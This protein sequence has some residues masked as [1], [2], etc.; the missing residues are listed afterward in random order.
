MDES[1]R[2][3]ARNGNVSDLYTLIQSDGNVLKRL[4]EIEFIDTPLHMAAEQG[5]MQFAMEMMNLKPSFSRKLNHQGLSP[6]HLALDK[7]HTEMVLHFVEIDKKLIRVKGKNSETPLHYITRVGNHNGLLDRFLQACPDS[8]RDFTTQNSTA[9]H[10]A[11]ENNRID[12][13]QVL[14]RTLVKKGPKDY[15]GEV[16][17]RKDENGNTALHMAAINNQPQADKCATNQSG[18]TALDVAQQHN[19]EDSIS[20]LRGCFI[21]VVSNFKPKLE[22]KFGNSVTKA[23]SL[24]FRDMDNIS[25][26]DRNALLVILGLLLT[27][28][29]Q[30]TLSP[31]GGISQSLN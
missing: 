30:A 10:I 8:I 22:K 15:Y 5:C 17:N 19:Y 31:P 27:A 28:T 25:G 6:I 1:L 21:P 12:V 7:G 23:S 29:Y 11:V 16:V 3:A 20:T 2:T 14:I 24:I 13:L 26:D 9:L 4:D 18:S